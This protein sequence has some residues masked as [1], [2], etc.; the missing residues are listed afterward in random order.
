MPLP[1]D[2]IFN[3]AEYTLQLDGEQ[4]KYLAG[5]ET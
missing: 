2:Y 1:P 5:E 4:A 3:L